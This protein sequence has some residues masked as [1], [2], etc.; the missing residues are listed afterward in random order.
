M[1]VCVTSLKTLFDLLSGIKLLTFI[2]QKSLRLRNVL[3]ISDFPGLV[4]SA[5]V[6]LIRF[7]RVYG[8]VQF[9]C[10]VSPQQISSLIYSFRCTCS[11]QYIGRTG[12]RLDAR[13]KQHVPTK[14]QLGNYFADHINNT[15]GSA[16]AEHLI[17]KR[18][19]VSTYSADLFTILSRS[20]SDVHL[21]VLETI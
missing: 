20:H 15:Y 1:C 2:R 7:L 6:T 19:C 11:L 18:D 21:K 8:S 17:N 5:I 13:I 9:M 10:C 4:R 14:I 12:Q 16:I 3:C